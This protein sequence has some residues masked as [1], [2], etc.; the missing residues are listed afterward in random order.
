MSTNQ[1]SRR[2][3]IQQT[4]GAGAALWLP[5]WA[6]GA[7]DGLKIATFRADVTPPEGHPLCGGWIT[8]VKTVADGLEAIG[9]VIVGA[10]SPIVLC[11]VDWTGILN[12][13]HIEW[14]AALAKAAGTSPER[15][16]VQCVHQH[17]APFV[18]LDTEKLLAA[19]HAGLTCVNVPYFQQCIERLQAAIREALLNARPLTQVA[20]GQARVERVAGNRRL[21]LGP[22]G[23]VRKMRGSACKD[24]EL[25]ALPEGVI[26]PMLKTVAFYSGDEKVACCHYY[27]THP[28]SYYGRGEVSSDFPG[29]ARK[30][31]QKE[32]PN[33]TQIYFTG[34]AGNIAAGKYNDGSPEARVAL[35]ERMYNA[36]VAAERGLTPQ[37][38][39]QMSW[40]THDIL[41]EVNPAFTKEGEL[42]MLVNGKNI[43]ANRIRPA[44]RA[45]WIERL[46]ARTPIILS[47]L[48]V[49]DATLL[50][51]P[52]ESFVEY[53]LR[54][55]S[56]A[57]SRFVATAAYGDGGA[58][59]I[60]TKEAYPQGGYE[61]SVANCSPNVDALLTAGIT[62]LLKQT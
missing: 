25:I 49:N 4:V 51:L 8:P 57:P 28:M 32:S 60:P 54:A 47:A 35:T 22:D 3:W 24:P 62:A 56:L 46:A 7:T 43:P 16:A 41:P 23:R 59:Y 34:A 48:H 20:T 9:L 6:Y 18:C 19:Q 30:R 50:H 5:A 31:R 12:R 13:A 33:C 26:D 10:G 38:I 52:A 58:W 15:V 14:R 39:R 61:V 53:Q 21:D 42:A 40:T 37:A 44:M 45:S 27:A 2:H 36:M 29:L 55:Q 1:L 17:D 11:A